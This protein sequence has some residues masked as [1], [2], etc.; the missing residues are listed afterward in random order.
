MNKTQY[1]AGKGTAYMTAEQ[2]IE[3]YQL[4]R[5][6]LDKKARECGAALKIGRNKRYVM[7]ILDKYLES[8]Q[9]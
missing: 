4:S 9:A 8:F 5:D 7:D 3:R 1:K 6:T 2:A